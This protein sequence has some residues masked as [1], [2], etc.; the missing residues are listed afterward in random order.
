MSDTTFSIE[1]KEEVWP[2]RNVFRISRG[3]RTESRVV[4]VTARDGAHVGRG[5][6]NPIRRYNQT[7]ASVLAEIE[8]VKAAKNLDRQKLQELLPPGAARN[9]LDCALWD[10]DAKRSGK[11]V[12]ELANVPMKPEVAT[13]FTISLDTPEKMAAAAKANATAPLLKLKLGGDDVDLARVE[14]VRDAAPASRLLI[15]ANESWSPEHYEKIVPS[16]RALAV[17][18]IEQPFPASADEVLK[19]LERPIPVCADE[20]CHTTVDLPR[21]KKRYEM[22]NVKLDK[23]GGLTEAL[24]LCKRARESGF[25]IL[26]GCMVGTSLSMAPAR[27]LASIADYVDLDG[28]LLLARDREPGLVYHNGLVAMPSSELWG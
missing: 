9:A 3:E 22:I 24:Q 1:A 23:T 26:V 16:L 5:E 20:S 2:L 14:N 28:P 12:W 10:L 17:E 19:N 25:E 6:A 18:L 7:T 27:V 13:S 8:S 15:D 4:V 21:L 11:R